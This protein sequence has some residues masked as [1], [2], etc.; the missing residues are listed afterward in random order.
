MQP[1][2]Q[3]LVTAATTLCESALGD[4]L[5]AIYLHGSVATG[6]AVAGISDLDCFLVTRGA[7]SDADTH[8]LA[9]LEARLLSEYPI[10]SEVH[11]SARST[12][13]LAADSFARFIL[14]YNSM[15]IFGRDIVREL[16]RIS[17]TLE[18]NAAT[19]KGRLPFARHCFSQA[20]DGRQPDC[21]GPLPSDPC[22]VSRKFARYF[23]VIEGA[24][25]LMSQNKFTSF[26]KEDVLTE[27]ADYGFADELALTRAVL[28]DAK[29]AAVEPDEF[30]RRVRPLVDWMFDTISHT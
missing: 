4:R 1:E 2:F 11:L 29:L 13:D 5:T 28:T 14:K 17:P 8:T 24:Y 22:Y 18:P 23:V 26:A 6:D 20:L 10:A 21:T 19:A 9:Q 16:D 25:F 7:L 15:L 12:D 27:L 30:L 3:P